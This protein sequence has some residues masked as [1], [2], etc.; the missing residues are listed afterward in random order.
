MCQ[1]SGG[2]IERCDANQIDEVL[3][4]ILSINILAT[5]VVYTVKLHRFFRFRNEPED[6]LSHNGSQLVLQIGAATQETTF[7]FE[8]ELKPLEE[9]FSL[10]E[11]TQS[12]DDLTE[13]PFQVVMTCLMPDT[14]LQ[15][16]VTSQKLPVSSDRAKLNEDVDNE[17][18]V[19]NVI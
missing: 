11:E 14:T 7:T 9:V 2:Q 1:E 10:I 8:Y 6:S 5:Q 18:I 16:R 15:T 4:D 19:A 13:V 17:M 3:D 12:L